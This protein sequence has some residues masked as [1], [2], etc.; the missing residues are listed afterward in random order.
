MLLWT[1]SFPNTQ[2]FL[3]TFR[4][5]SNTR[6]VLCVASMGLSKHG[7]PS[8]RRVPDFQHAC[9]RGG[10]SPL[11]RVLQASKPVVWRQTSPYRPGSNLTTDPSNHSALTQ[12]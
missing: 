7:S 1:V 3:I 12:H 11:K 10:G 9:A 6:V 5:L 4:G 2:P 8:D